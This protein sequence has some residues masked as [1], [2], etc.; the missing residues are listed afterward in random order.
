MAATST[1][2]RSIAR[3]ALPSC[4]LFE[5][6]DG[7]FWLRGP[8][9]ERVKKL[10]G[11]RVDG[12]AAGFDHITSSTYVDELS[13]QRVA[14]GI[15]QGNL[16]RTIQLQPT[17]NPRPLPSTPASLAPAH[18]FGLAELE[19]LE[20][21]ITARNSALQATLDRIAHDLAAGRSSTFADFGDLFVYQ[22]AEN[23]Y[24]VDWEL[25]TMP[26]STVELLALAAHRAGRLLPCRLV[27]PKP[28][29]RD[30]RIRPPRMLQVT[31]LVPY[32]QLR[33]PL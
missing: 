32:G 30:G 5:E 2:S 25:T 12:D 19:D 8:D 7:I 20:R 26:S 22:V 31:E 18:L 29:R 28:Q 23:V 9:L 4:I 3:G 24:E 1:S 10:L 15:R 16:V 21:R 11:L 6:Q 17:K 33:L 27:P 14:V 13:K